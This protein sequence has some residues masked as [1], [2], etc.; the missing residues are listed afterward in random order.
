MA[1]HDAIDGGKV[2][3]RRGDRVIG[4]TGHWVIAAMKDRKGKTTTGDTG[5][6]R[7]LSHQIIGR[8]GLLAFHYRFDQ[9][10][11]PVPGDLHPDTQKNEGDHTQDAV[12]GLGT[13]ALSESRGVGVTE[14]H[15]DAQS[16]DGEDYADVSAD[17]VDNA[18]HGGMRAEG[19]R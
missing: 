6:H 18:P 4:A 3:S 15:A 1:G 8:D 17:V 14:I 7:L 9:R 12:R 19:E 13:N 2:Q 16:D 10:Y 5:E 11:R